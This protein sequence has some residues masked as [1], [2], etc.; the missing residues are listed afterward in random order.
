MILAEFAAAPRRPAADTAR[1][2][3]V[4][5]AQTH[6]N[7]PL[8]V[9]W[10]AR[11]ASHQDADVLV[12][13]D[14]FLTGPIADPAVVAREWREHG[15][16]VAER[17]RGAFTVV[18]WDAA[19]ARGMVAGDHAAARSCLLY[20]QPG[21]LLFG[22]H[23]PSLRRLMRSDPGP[24][25]AVI[26]PWIAPRYLQGRRTMTRGVVRLG[27]ASLLELDSRGWRRRRFWVPRWREPRDVPREELPGLVREELKRSVAARLPA[28]PDEPV[29]L[30]LSGGVDS[31]V[32]A[33]T[34]AMAAPGR[35]RAYSTLFPEWRAADE[36]ERIATTTSALGIP[37][38]RATMK[39]QGALR[40]ALEFLQRSGTVPGGP[41][42][43]VERPLLER[44]AADGVRVMFDGQGGDEVFGWSPYYPADLIRRAR[45]LH[46]MRLLTRIPD[47]GRRRPSRRLLKLM[48]I[49]FG[50][51]PAFG[52]RMPRRFRT[53]TEP[54]MPTWLTATSRRALDEAHDPWPWMRSDV[55]RW[56]A[57]QSY[58]L[59]RSRE[60]SA[61]GEYTWLRGA[62]LGLESRTP[63]FDVEL[64][65]LMLSLPPETGWGRIN[66][67][68]ARAA[69]AGVLP[70]PVR[71]NPRK[72]NIG[73]F[74]FDLLTGP[75]LP[76][77]RELLLDP[78]ARV[79]EFAGG[80]GFDDYV[81]RTRTRADPDWL[82]WTTT[83]WR[84]VTAECWLRWSEDPAW[85]D[86]LLARPDLP[87]PGVAL[88]D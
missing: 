67:P 2:L 56:W 34:M 40:I 15:S 53:T 55:P 32:V 69:V 17:L 37:S 59:T 35:L 50:V 24:E 42:L 64:T 63:L 54:D 66:R 26:A 36:S 51:R 41:G 25:P 13:V 45:L 87:S 71:M 57:Y 44:A 81:A 7:G 27:G 83:L 39:P 65:E 85:V 21:T 88:R 20:E 43:L 8:R 48:L 52:P 16:S 75:D 84:L 3:D 1:A 38:V 33:A 5:S 73:P 11:V 30:I 31:S 10:D 19:N 9:S 14:G 76:V 77:I 46:L 29:G 60:G 72:A 49:D 6:E 62:D 12:L 82:T 18:V 70:D 80:P 28:D 79:R 4:A 58:L 86:G 61:L 74:Y 22:T 23:L 78:A 47:S 68:V